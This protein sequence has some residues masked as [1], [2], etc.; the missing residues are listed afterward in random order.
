MSCKVGDTQ[1]SELGEGSAFPHIPYFSFLS[2]TLPSVKG[3]CGDAGRDSH[4]AG[5]LGPLTPNIPRILHSYPA[6]RRITF[7]EGKPLAQGH[8]AIWW[9][10]PVREPLVKGSG[11]DWARLSASPPQPQDRMG[12]CPSGDSEE[13]GEE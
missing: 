12:H 7:R 8:R 6:R 4:S 11:V 2:L 10:S 13:Q 9:W 5:Q 3:E 1:I